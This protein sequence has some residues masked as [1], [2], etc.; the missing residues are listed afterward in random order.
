MPLVGLLFWTVIVVAKMRTARDR[1][2]IVSN[3]CSDIDDYEGGYE[4]R[5]PV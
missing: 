1:M 3:F 2:M 5:G 4:E